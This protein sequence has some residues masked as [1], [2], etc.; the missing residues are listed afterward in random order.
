[1]TDL[2]ASL[3]LVNFDEFYEEE[4]NYTD[5]PNITFEL[6]QN[7]VPCQP[8]PISEA[9]NI[10]V[11]VFYIVVFLLAIP[12]NLIVGLVIGS[13]R[14]SLSPSE[15]YLFHLMVA[16]TLLAL[17]LPFSATS[18][19]RGWL[20]GDLLCKLVSLVKEANFYTSIL[21]LVCI[22]M[23]RYMVIVRAMEARKTQRRLC[24]WAVCGVVWVLGLLLSLPALYNE[25]FTRKA[26]EPQL[27]AERYELDTADEWRLATRIMRH[28]LGFL[29]PLAF[30]LTCYSVT[31][32]RL[33]RTRG[34]RRQKAMRVIV[35][36]VVAFLFCWTPFHVA[37]IVDTLLRAKLVES[38]CYKRGVVDVAMFATQ[39]LG[40]LHCCV[41]PVLYAFVGEK[42]RRRFTQMLYKSGLRER[43]SVSRST[44]ST[45][46]SSE[47]TSNFL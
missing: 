13:N 44:R 37:T 27:C 10:A 1:M 33:L 22:S 31:I 26:S 14:Q 24:S 15:V 7:T 3:Q 42:F 5:F 32:A 47:P 20:F 34:F 9:I 39:S 40:L 6:D 11:C 8:I 12:G 43:T 35:A 23:D 38:D 36:V 25:A 19:I 16:D 45:S 41:N 18:L 4:F 2:N 29:L 17:I 21:F 28:L 46:Q 30:M